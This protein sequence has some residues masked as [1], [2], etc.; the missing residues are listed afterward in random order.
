MT[1]SDMGCGAIYCIS[2]LTFNNGRAANTSRVSI[3]AMT[4]TLEY[5]CHE[6]KMFVPV[7]EYEWY[8]ANT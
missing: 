2:L 4:L 8:I 5:A 1:I 7:G 3:G 6:M